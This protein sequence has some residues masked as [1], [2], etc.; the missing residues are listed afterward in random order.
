MKQYVLIAICLILGAAMYCAG[1]D[2]PP[3]PVTALVIIDIQEFYFPGGKVPLSQPE[4]AAANARRLLDVFRAR[5]WP[6]IHVRHEFEPGG[7]IRPIVAPR[8][9]ETVITKH[10]V[11]AFLNTPL[12]ELLQQ[13]KI[14]RLVLVGMQTHMCLEAAVRAARDSGFQCLVAHD[15]CATRDLPFG[16]RMV[17]AADVHAATLATLQGTYAQVRSTAELLAGLAE[18]TKTLE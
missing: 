18:E 8:S 6:V 11:N 13:Q 14:E 1:D 9:N 10:A 2:S 12:L 5:D 17:A 3:A 7:D 16:D 4:A 15:A